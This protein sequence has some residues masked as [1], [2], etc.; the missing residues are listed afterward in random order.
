[1][2]Y[3]IEANHTKPKPVYAHL[4]HHSLNLGDDVWFNIA[5]TNGMDRVIMM[6]EMQGDEPYRVNCG[7]AEYEAL[8]TAALDISDHLFAQYVS[9]MHTLLD[10]C[11]VWVCVCVCVYFCVR[12]SVC[13]CVCLCVCVCVCVCVRVR[14]CVCEFVRV[15]VFVCVCMC[16]CALMPT[17]VCA[18]ACL[19][20]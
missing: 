9:L 20:L 14:A 10:L 11:D 6:V 5:K 17:C 7:R 15:Y 2:V 4:L 19:C 16:V 8:Y 12:V 13:V 3:L 1:M 18:H